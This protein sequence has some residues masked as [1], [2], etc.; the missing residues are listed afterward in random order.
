MHKRKSKRWL[1][2]A[3]AT[4]AVAAGA[5]AF[6]PTL[7]QA[8]SDAPQDAGVQADFS[9]AAAK[10]DVP[11]SVL[12]AVTHEESGW[13]SHKGYSNK[14]GYGLADLT[15]VTKDM[16]VNGDAG[17]G[18]RSDL[19][20]MIDHPEMH[21]LQKAAELT[22]IP[23]DKLRT[24]RRSNLEGAAALLASYQKSVGGGLSKDPS[25]W[26]GAVAK[27][28][29]L[30][31]EKAATSY[32]DNVFGTIRSGAQQK[33]ADGRTV[34]LAADPSAKPV[35]AQMDKLKL[36][37]R[38]SSTGAE[39]P[40]SMDCTFD[41]VTI[42]GNGQVSNRPANGI[43]IDRIVLH[44]AEGSF[45]SAKEELDASGAITAAHYLMD[46]DGTT[47]QLMANKDLAFA[48][49][50][51]HYNLHSIS[52]EQ[53][54]FTARG[55]DWY[56]DAVYQ[57]T[58][59]LV[60]YLAKRY[61]VPM[62][63]QHILGHD[64]VP[65][66]LDSN[67]AAQHWDKGTAWD[68]SRF[69]RLAGS[70]IDSGTRG[71]GKVGSVVTIAPKFNAKNE[72]TYTVCPSDDPSGATPACAEVP[73]PS[74]SLFVRTA[75]ASDAPLFLD[76]VVHPGAQAGTDSISDWSDH[77]QAGQQ[78]VVADVKGDWTAIWYG[79]QEGWIHNPGGKYT[80]PTTGVQIIKAAGTTAAPVYGQ[81]YP[82]ASEYPAGLS[83]S[84]Q[85]PLTAANYK[86]P[87]GQAYVADQPAT[88]ADDFFKSGGQVVTGSETYY[89][90]QFNHRT[91][92]V[93]SADVTATPAA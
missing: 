65:G 61:D 39:C 18:G 76:P 48:V 2:G 38:P 35:T 88:P 22:G 50:N 36:K 78:F 34:K 92:Y 32:V 58:A 80:I 1:T 86:I 62:D 91:I 68:W 72:Q 13:Q 66:S 5:F 56:T 63:R 29:R 31:D 59:K 71:V 10:Y 4:G 67:L 21:T 89:Q 73:Q 69:M 7:A 24:D 14:G 46:T 75:P 53:A 23:A 85:A 3:V 25:D 41:P 33:S 79:G 26:T 27:Y 52:I 6:L 42:A 45:E 47:T 84:T 16:L 30:P 19:A 43:K 40:A 74:N 82:A 83:P 9:A 77:V 49:G 15:D 12:M 60:K 55:A 90:V 8:Q 57:Q 54:G 81:A 70:P 17:A 51:Y 28:S 11:T 64:N 87:V 44:T 93:N 37:N 20:S